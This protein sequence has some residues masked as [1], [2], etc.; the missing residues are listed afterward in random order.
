MSSI[1]VEDF[2]IHPAS[3]ESIKKFTLTNKNNIRV[4]LT[5]YG[6]T[7]VSLYTPDRNGCYDDILLGFDDIKGYFDNRFFGSTIGR[8]ANRICKGQFSLDDETYQLACNNGDNHLHGGDNG[9]DKKVWL[10]QQLPNGIAFKLDSPGGDEGYPGQLSVVSTYIL[11][12][13]NE[14]KMTLEGDV[15]DRSTIVNLTNHAFINLS[16]QKCCSSVVD[17]TL[18]INATQYLPCHDMIPTGELKQVDALFDFRSPKKIGDHISL[19]DGGYDHNFCLDKTK[20]YNARIYHEVSGRTLEISTNQPGIQFYSGNFLNV[21]G[22]NGNKYKPRDALCLEPQNYPDAINQSNFP[23][24]V[25]L[26]GEKYVNEI[27]WKLSTM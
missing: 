13:D 27:T 15:K 12:G 17:H 11:N 1:L 22:K 25:L 14:L 24:P 23:S 3:G 6:A 26:P 2:G 19:V 10:W 9:F 7:L 5:N 20:S 16:G 8:H 18:E 4:V 21:I